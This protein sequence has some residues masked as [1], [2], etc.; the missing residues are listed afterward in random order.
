M[1][2]DC[3]RKDELMQQYKSKW[4]SKKSD[5]EQAIGERDRLKREND[6]LEKSLERKGHYLQT[7][8][9]KHER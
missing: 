8:K 7:M 2:A 6:R 5:F 9:A 1:K 3:A 4:E